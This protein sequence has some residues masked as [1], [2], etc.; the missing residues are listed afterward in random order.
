MKRNTK[1][2]LLLIT[3]IVFFVSMVLSWLIPIKSKL[4]GTQLVHVESSRPIQVAN[5]DADIR[6]NGV[7]EDWDNNEIDYCQVEVSNAD[8]VDSNDNYLAGADN[9]MDE[10]VIQSRKPIHGFNYYQR[11]RHDYQIKNY[12]YTNVFGH[13]WFEQHDNDQDTSRVVEDNSRQIPVILHVHGS[14]RVGKSWRSWDADYKLN[15]SG[16]KYKLDELDD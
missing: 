13:S 7:Q 10:E 16:S 12:E 9:A 15:P 1:I 2:V 4:L 8:F 11:T 5:I 3:I 14:Y 6:Y